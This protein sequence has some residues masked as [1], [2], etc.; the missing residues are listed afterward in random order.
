VL[1]AWHQQQL[2]L[3]HGRLSCIL[4]QLLAHRV[5]IFRKVCAPCKTS[6]LQA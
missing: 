1:L 2:Q 6:D 3:G 4:L 5:A